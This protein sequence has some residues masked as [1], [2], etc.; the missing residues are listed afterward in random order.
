MDS[1]RSNSIPAEWKQFDVD[2]LQG[3]VLILGGTDTGK[4]TLTRYI[5]DR[6]IDTGQPLAHL[7]GDPGQG[8]LGPPCTM[9]CRVYG[10]DTKLIANHQWFVGSV[11]PRGHMLSVLVGAK[12]LVEKVRS[13]NVQVLVYDTTGLVNPEGGGHYLKQSKIELLNPST[14]I[15]LQNKD[16]LEPI[17]APVRR[18][19]SIQLIECSASDSARTR[20]TNERRK[21]R[22]KRFSEVFSDCGSLAVPV[23]SLPVWPRSQ[24]ERHRLVALTE[25][26]GFVISLG[27]VERFHSNDETVILKTPL[28][29]LDGVSSL[30]IGAIYLDPV[31]FRDQQAPKP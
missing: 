9:S 22:A 25:E 7:D 26:S 3:N 12:R 5:T 29:T 1:P 10:K 13:E 6:L 31:T 30:K 28:E 17:L 4:T 20:D 8:E 18:T 24:F 27:I 15:A 23:D 2:N 19:S 11:T 16:E 21:Y 14:I